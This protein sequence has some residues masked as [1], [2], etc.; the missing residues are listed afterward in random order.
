M[1]AHALI[2]LA[3]S[4]WVLILA[5]LP[6]VRWVGL[7]LLCLGAAY[8]AL[9]FQQ[10]GQAHRWVPTVIPLGVET[11]LMFL[12][13]G[14]L[15]YFQTQKD[16]QKIF[17]AFGFYVPQ[18]V[19][20][21]I[22]TSQSGP[23]GGQA[24]LVDDGVCMSTDAGQFTQLAETLNPMPLGA[25]MNRYYASI[26]PQVQ[27]AGG[28]VSDVVG[29]AMLALWADASQGAGNYRQACRCALRIVT[30]VERFNR[31]EEVQLPIR[32]GIH[33]G[34][35]RLGNV[36]SQ[37]HYEYR[38]LGDTVN[39]ASRIENLNKRLGTRILL[40]GQ[41]LGEYREFLTRELGE[42]LLEGKTVSLVIH[43]LLGLRD[44][45]P[46]ARTQER[47]SKQF[48]AALACF[49]LGDLEQARMRFDELQ[50][51]YPEDGPAIFYAYLCG[52]MME[53]A[54]EERNTQVIRLE[55][56]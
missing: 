32:I 22:L 49:R 50:N 43:E 45:S 12:L 53:L 15:R 16:R 47:L 55:K 37:L 56:Y 46:R 4:A 39:T 2:P 11:P 5:G 28:F 21:R 20:E 31:E 35:F 24:F 36:G 34:A 44:E 38:A 13:I 8:F 30:A 26:F 52:E 42:F 25:L 29:D 23:D 14:G 51:A 27:E 54:P 3:W 41:V 17:H 33:A 48:A 10:F 1:F 6:R 40:S 19:V 9:S 7:A 18:S